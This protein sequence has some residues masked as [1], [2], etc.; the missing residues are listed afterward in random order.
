M[1]FQVDEYN[2]V[3]TCPIPKCGK[4]WDF[5]IV[6]RVAD[7]D[8]YEYIDYI[9]KIDERKQ[10][11]YIKCPACTAYI[12]KPFDGSIKVV[13]LECNSQTICYLCLNQ[14]KDMNSDTI[15]GNDS[16][17]TNIAS[18]SIQFHPSFLNNNNNNNIIANIPNLNNNNN[19]NNNL[20]GP[21]GFY[22]GGSNAFYFNQ[23]NYISNN[24][25]IIIII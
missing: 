12:D 13:C 14:W 4:F 24:I 23:N 10:L 18:N 22:G 8:N 17:E 3:I 20:Y 16:C 1:L 7:M 11:E 6:S 15:C 2:W 9:K 5:D 19:N 25:I 21:N